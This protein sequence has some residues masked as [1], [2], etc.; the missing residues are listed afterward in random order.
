ML[1]V[2]DLI[3]GFGALVESDDL[4]H[5]PLVFDYGAESVLS[6]ELYWAKLRL[7]IY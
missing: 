6:L 3:H 7:I 4:I 1:G 2:G 5:G